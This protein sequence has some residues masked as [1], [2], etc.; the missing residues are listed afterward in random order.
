MRHSWGRRRR[1]RRLC[2]NHHGE[3][4]REGKNGSKAE[5][6]RV[7]SGTIIGEDWHRYNVAMTP[8]STRI[9]P[10]TG[11]AYLAARTVAPRD[12]GHFA[13]HL[14][15]ARQGGQRPFPCF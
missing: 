6:H 5:G 7:A 10:T 8:L 15:V 9:S 2:R 13:R 14:D 4:Y 1:A 11:G 3:K 12:E